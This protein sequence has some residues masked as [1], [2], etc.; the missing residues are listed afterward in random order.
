MKTQIVILL[1]L[2]AICFSAAVTEKQV[3]ENLPL[4]YKEGGAFEPDILRPEDYFVNV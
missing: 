2:A 4:I 3:M 1:A